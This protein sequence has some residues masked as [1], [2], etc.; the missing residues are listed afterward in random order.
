MVNPFSSVGVTEL[1]GQQMYIALVILNTLASILLC[2]CA[3]S[4]RVF[5]CVWVTDLQ[6]LLSTLYQLKLILLFLVSGQLHSTAPRF[7]GL[8]PF[9]RIPPVLCA[10]QLW[11]RNLS[12]FPVALPQSVFI[13]WF[14]HLKEAS[15]AVGFATSSW[16][17]FT[18]PLPPTPLV[19]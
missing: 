10:I 18:L 1:L 19:S 8:H 9:S 15:H 3:K 11:F 6:L 5:C 14:T 12:E 4:R 7:H 2:R 17:F 16:S 13:L